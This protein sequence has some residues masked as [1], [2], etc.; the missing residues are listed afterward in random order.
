MAAVSQGQSSALDN[1]IDWTLTVLQKS[2]P[3]VLSAAALCE[4]GKWGHWKGAEIGA[5]PYS[6]TQSLLGVRVKCHLTFG[7]MGR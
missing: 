7:A 4:R 6:L 2:A 3:G 1:V 5:P